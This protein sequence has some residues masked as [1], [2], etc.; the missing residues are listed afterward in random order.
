VEY[1]EAGDCVSTINGL[2]GSS[3]VSGK[4]EVEDSG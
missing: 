3:I 1:R 4:K 2:P